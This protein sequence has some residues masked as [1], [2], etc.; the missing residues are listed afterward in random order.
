MLHP[1]GQLADRNVHQ[2]RNAASA[3]LHIVSL[4]AQPRSAT[5]GANRLATIAG[6]HHSVLYLV[7]PL[8]QVFEEGID[9]H[10]SP[11]PFLGRNLPF[12]RNKDFFPSQCFL[13]YFTLHFGR[14]AVPQP[15]LFLL[16]Q[17]EIR[18]EDG[19]ATF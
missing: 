3:H 9:G 17:F 13:S 15:V 14:C 5:L 12:G 4:G 18:L 6:Q 16:R 8:A 1:V 7:L 19:E 2:F 11:L 10:Q